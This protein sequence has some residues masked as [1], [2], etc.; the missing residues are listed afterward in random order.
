MSAILVSCRP[1]SAS[2]RVAAAS[3][4]ERVRSRRRSKRLPPATFSDGAFITEPSF[5]YA[6]AGRASRGG[7]LESPS[8]ARNLDGLARRG[9]QPAGL[10][11][12]DGS[13]PVLHGH[14]RSVRDA[15]KAR[16]RAQHL[17][18]RRQGLRNRYGRALRAANGIGEPEHVIADQLSLG[19]GHVDETRASQGG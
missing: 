2:T 9:R 4:S 19:A 10:R 7:S 5:T 15:W 16:E 13:R 3:R 1:F 6:D 11:D 18:H 8:E 14:R 12:E 17:P